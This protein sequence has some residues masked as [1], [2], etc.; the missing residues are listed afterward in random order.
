MTVL[1]ERPPPTSA[2]I[3]AEALGVVALVHTPTV[4]TRALAI[5]PT[6]SA[7]LAAA[8]HY[9]FSELVYLGDDAPAQLRKPSRT[10]KSFAHIVSGVKDLPTNWVADVIGVAVPGLP[11]NVLAMARTVSGPQ[12]V[13]VVAVDRYSAGQTAKRLLERSWQFVVPFREYLPDPQLYFLVSDTRLTIKRPV[14]AWTRRIS[15]GYLPALFKFP[16][17]EYA[18]FNAP[19]PPPVAVNIRPQGSGQPIRRASS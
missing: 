10:R 12:T 4:A 13:L 17:D 15:E 11:D 14:P 7:V 19:R 18:A 9:P 2:D 16:K 5:G 6:A 8:S 3:F 1:T